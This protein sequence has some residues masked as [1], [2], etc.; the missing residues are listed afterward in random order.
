MEIAL[1]VI[2]LT[3]LLYFLLKTLLFPNVEEKKS[4]EPEWI[5]VE[6]YDKGELIGYRVAWSERV[7]GKRLLVRHYL[8][9]GTPADLRWCKVAAESNAAIFNKEKRCPWEFK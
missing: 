6:V 8:S 2:V 5:V 7:N 4:K 9:D 1:T 3:A